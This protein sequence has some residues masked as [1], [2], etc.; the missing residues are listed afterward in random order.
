MQFVIIIAT[1]NL[2]LDYAIMPIEPNFNVCVYT[3]YML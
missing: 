1:V 2:M 3:K